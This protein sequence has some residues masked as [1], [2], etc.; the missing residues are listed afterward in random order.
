VG[1]ALV[2]ALSASN[3][4]VIPAPIDAI[5]TSV[6]EAAGDSTTGVFGNLLPNASWPEAFFPL[7]DV[8]GGTL[9]M[10]GYLGKQQTESGIAELRF[11]QDC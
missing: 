1:G 2:L 3:A 7:S 10:I 5:V 8:V 9:L 4:V 11:R 6:A